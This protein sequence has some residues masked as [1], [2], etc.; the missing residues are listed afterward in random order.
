MTM[1]PTKQKSTTNV[2]RRMF[3]VMM[4]MMM[5]IKM[6]IL[7]TMMAMSS[8]MLI[9]CRRHGR[10]YH[11]IISLWAL[12]AW[13]TVADAADD[14]GHGDS[15]ATGRLYHTWTGTILCGLW[16]DQALILGDCCILTE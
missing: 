6:T 5:M 11:R 8:V 15:L 10:Y 4:M 2:K 14:D 13:C 7:A 1:T 12:L 16:R 3:E 9:G